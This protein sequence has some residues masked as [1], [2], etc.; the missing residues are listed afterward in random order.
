MET[1]V[2]LSSQQTLVKRSEEE[3]RLLL[4]D[5]K[6][7]GYPPIL[8]VE[9]VAEIASCSKHHVYRSLES[10]DLRGSKAA[11][12]WRITLRAVAIWVVG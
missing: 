11:G 8:K 9:Q 4:A 10:N 1:Y 2:R 7:A 12:G 3:A 5:L 6:Q